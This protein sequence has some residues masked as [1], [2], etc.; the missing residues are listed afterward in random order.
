MSDFSAYM[1]N[2]ISSNGKIMKAIFI[3][4]D[5]RIIIRDADEPKHIDV[6]IERWE[7]LTGK[8]A[9]KLN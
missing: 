4:E 6:I 9:V 3:T 2:C 1:I 7:T 5:K 8:K